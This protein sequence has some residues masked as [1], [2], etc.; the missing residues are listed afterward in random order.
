[1]AARD[2]HIIL[3]TWW[4]N[5]PLYS[6]SKAIQL[7]WQ[8]CAQGWS[9][10]CTYKWPQCCARES[11]GMWVSKR[12]TVF[13]HATDVIEVS[14]AKICHLYTTVF[15]IFKSGPK[16]AILRALFITDQFGFVCSG[17][18]NSCA[19]TIYLLTNM[20]PFEPFFL[21]CFLC[22]FLAALCSFHIHCQIKNYAS[23]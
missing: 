11:W 9:L 3:K 14:H 10:C 5:T 4:L 21:N 7:K 23:V 12:A 20:L 1:M 18:S 16:C 6:T 2:S 13:V 22:I 15:W 19:L 17:I 8:T